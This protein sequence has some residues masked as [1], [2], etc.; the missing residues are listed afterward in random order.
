MFLSISCTIH[1]IQYLVIESR[2]H[3]NLHFG[4]FFFNKEKD[5]QT[6]VSGNINA[7]RDHTPLTVQR[8]SIV[9]F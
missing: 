2:A 4:D 5:I 9:Y 8:Y 1:T 3:R 7:K 6:R